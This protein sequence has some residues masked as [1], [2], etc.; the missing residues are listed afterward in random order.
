MSGWE[1]IRDIKVLVEENAISKLYGE[2][3][4]IQAIITAVN[5]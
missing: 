2:P 4:L 3:L 5:N 1:G